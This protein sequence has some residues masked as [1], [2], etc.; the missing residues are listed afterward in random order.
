MN[1]IILNDQ[2]FFQF[3]KKP[4]LKEQLKFVAALMKSAEQRVD[5]AM[6]FR[7][8][9][10]NYIFFIGLSLFVVGGFYIGLMLSEVVMP[11]AFKIVGFS[12]YWVGV[13]SMTFWEQIRTFLLKYIFTYKDEN[14][15]ISDLSIAR[16]Y[17]HQTKDELAQQAYNNVIEL[18]EHMDD[19]NEVVETAWDELH[20]YVPVTV[21]DRESYERWI[22]RFSI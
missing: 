2:S 9:I 6:N 14:E 19:D 16:S 20:S 17:Y 1:Q 13:I 22:N 4:D 15:A 3:P 21:T 5:K 12:C 8:K 18:G 10:K 11:K 7:K